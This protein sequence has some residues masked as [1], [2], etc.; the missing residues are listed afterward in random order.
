MTIIISYTK[1]SNHPHSLPLTPPPPNPTHTKYTST[2]PIFPHLSIKNVP[3]TPVTQNI[4]LSTFTYAH[5]PMKNVY[6]PHPPKI[7]FYP[8]LQTLYTPRKMSNHPTSTQN[9]P[10]PTHL[11]SPIKN[12]HP[13]YPPNIYLHLSPTTPIHP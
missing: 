7:Y 4:P 11:H 10:T 8:P 9:I 6:P 1:T 5:S 2:N 3:S 12:I 13:L